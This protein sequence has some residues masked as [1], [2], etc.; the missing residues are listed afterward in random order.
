[1]KIYKAIALFAALTTATGMME[2]TYNS[3]TPDFNESSPVVVSKKHEKPFHKNVHAKKKTKQHK[4]IHASTKKVK[5]GVGGA[6]GL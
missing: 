6:G 5:R 4:N 3:D 2:A 1:M